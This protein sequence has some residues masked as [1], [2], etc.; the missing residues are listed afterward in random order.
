MYTMIIHIP[1]QSTFHTQIRRH[2]WLPGCA[3]RRFL[4]RKK[5][6]RCFQNHSVVPTRLYRQNLLELWHITYFCDRDIWLTF[7]PWLHAV[8]GEN[9][10]NPPGQNLPLKGH[11]VGHILESSDIGNGR[12]FL[13]ESRRQ[14]WHVDKDAHRH[15][16]RHTDRLLDRHRHYV[17]VLCCKSR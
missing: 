4:K 13:I 11:F 12:I 5:S 14:T 16:N 10:Q 9:G 17:L 7:W 1:W 15:T 6:F 3:F 2:Q 8:D